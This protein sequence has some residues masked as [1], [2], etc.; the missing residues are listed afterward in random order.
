MHLNCNQSFMCT[1]LL[2]IT[3]ETKEFND[4]F[5]VPLTRSEIITEFG[6]EKKNI[7]IYTRWYKIN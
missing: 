2:D 1:H 3:L 4:L 5:L 7:L 6:E